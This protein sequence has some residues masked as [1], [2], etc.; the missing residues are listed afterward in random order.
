MA[1]KKE[2][3]AVLSSFS[4]GYKV[5]VLINGIDVGITGGKSESMRLFVQGSPLAV[6]AP[7]DFKNLFCLKEG[8]NI[9]LVEFAKA[10][11][12]AHDKAEVSLQVE[13]HKEPLFFLQ[14][15]EASGKVE[16]KVQIKG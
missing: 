2:I 3:D 9:I 5:K 7:S 15:R 14:S 16:K 12:E 8:T 10:S 1:A 4:Y 11:T 13:G 6:K